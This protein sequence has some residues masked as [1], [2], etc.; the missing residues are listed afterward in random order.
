MD[1]NTP[2]S[3][4]NLPVVIHHECPAG[5]E[6]RHSYLL[7]CLEQTVKYNAN[8]VLIGSRNWEQQLPAGVTFVPA[9]EL[10]SPRLQA[11][12]AVY[13]DL[14]P[15]YGGHSLI[16]FRRLFLMETFMRKYGYRNMVLLDSDI[17]VYQDLS[18][19]ER[20]LSCDFGCCID[21]DQHFSPEDTQGLRWFA[22]CGISYWTLEALDSF[23]GY[24]H[25][26][27]ANHL[28]YLKTKLDYHITHNIPGG[29][30]EMSLIYL[31]VRDTPGL[32]FYNM[33]IPENGCAFNNSVWDARNYSNGEYIVNSKIR[34]KKFTFEAP[35]AMPTFYLTDGGKVHCYNIHF[36]GSAKAYMHDFRLYGSL[37]WRSKVKILTQEWLLHGLREFAHG[38]S[39]ASKAVHTFGKGV[40]TILRLK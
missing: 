14:A 13:V 7:D 22:N 16:F 12:E 19:F 20:F 24:C 4:H 39:P 27:Y 5:T 38:D 10:D 1:S 36:V 37:T 32:R 18:R 17:L 33:A 30:T 25:D 28:D 8:T 2:Y 31:W 15:Y 35:D 23:L 11:F 40:K 29:V 26:A 34:M 3:L 9:E 21:E 6:E